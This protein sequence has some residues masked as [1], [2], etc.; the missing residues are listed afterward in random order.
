MGQAHYGKCEVD[1]YKDIGNR[2]RSAMKERNI[3]N[4]NMACLL[5]VSPAT[6]SQWLMGKKFTTRALQNISEKLDLSINW[7]VFGEGHHRRTS[8]IVIDEQEE[9]L[10]SIIQH[11][12]IDLSRILS[13][14]IQKIAIY[15]QGQK[16]NHHLSANKIFSLTHLALISVD[17]QGNIL[18]ANP[19]FSDV[20]RYN[21]QQSVNIFDISAAEYRAN[22]Q[23]HLQL[24]KETGKGDYHYH[25]FIDPVTKER[26]AVIIKASASSLS[27]QVVVDILI[28][29]IE[30][31]E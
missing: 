23:K 7:L 14:L 21:T 4:S 10:L 29:P 26:I 30:H 8:S 19:F 22:L 12:H 27:G 15:Q 16:V 9:A 18:K 1:S 2:L 20:L 11:I 13:E 3:S 28:K 25:E 5:E 31:H 17:L 6:V 24:I